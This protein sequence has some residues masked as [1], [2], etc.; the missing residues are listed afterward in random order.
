MHSTSIQLWHDGKEQADIS[1]VGGEVG[2]G[3]ESVGGDEQDVGGVSS[4]GVTYSF[5]LG[6]TATSKLDLSTSFVSTVWWDMS[7]KEII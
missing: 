1:V 7:T 2:G 3:D 4:W 5:C 6:I